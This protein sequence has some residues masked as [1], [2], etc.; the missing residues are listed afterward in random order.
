VNSKKFD[1]GICC[2]VVGLSLLTA[3]CQV[4]QKAIAVDYP[5]YNEIIRQTEDEH[6]L[7]NLVRLRYV[8]GIPWRTSQLL[9]QIQ[10][11]LTRKIVDAVK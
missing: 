5:G 2:V 6:M 8:M 10:N 4:G 11:T 7:L 3:G 9:E 1:L